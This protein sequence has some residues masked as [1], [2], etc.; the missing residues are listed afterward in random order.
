MYG[1]E[2]AMI[3]F[4]THFA[5]G[6]VSDEHRAGRSKVHMKRLRGGPAVYVWESVVMSKHF[7]D[8]LLVGERGDINDVLRRLK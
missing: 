2:D 4:G 7:D 3:D 5:A 1:L 6:A 8:D